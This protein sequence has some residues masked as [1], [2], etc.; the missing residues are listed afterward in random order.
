MRKALFLFLASLTL[1]SCDDKP[2]KVVDSIGGIKDVVIVVDSYLWEDVV[3]DTLRYHLAK[4]VDGLIRDEPLF[5]LNQVK[6]ASF[7]GLLKK[8]RNFIYIKIAQESKVNVAQDRYASPQTGIIITGKDE[9]TIARLIGENAEIIIQILTKAE[10][11][12]KQRLMQNVRMDAVPFKKQ[13]G[14]DINIPKAYRYAKTASDFFWIRKTINEGTM[15]LMF[16]EMPLE[17]IQRDSS[18]VSQIVRVR[19]SVGG[20]NIVVD[21][22]GV[23]QTEPML[24]PFLNEVSIAGQFAYETKGTWEVKNMFM[25]G[26][27]VNYAIYNPTKKNWLIAEGYVSAPNSE[28]RNYMF[29]LEAILKSITFLNKEKSA[30]SVQP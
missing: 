14:I 21:D 4:P 22:P 30:S 26:P 1:V 2:I 29:E 20:K 5:T 9:A 18:I 23:F 12:E 16:Y 19:D 3:G 6:P 24:S 17:A 10:I 11:K 13:F 27:F 8:S 28:Q 25:A 7:E 15:D